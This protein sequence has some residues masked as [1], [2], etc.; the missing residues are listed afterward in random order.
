MEFINNSLDKN[1]NWFWGISGNYSISINFINKYANK[2][3]GCVYLSYN[4]NLSFDDIINNNN[5]NY[6][7]NLD[8]ISNNSMKFSKIRWINNYRLKII[9]ALQIQRHLRNCISNPLFKLSR[10]KIINMLKE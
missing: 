10:N 9:K 7:W 2:D 5:S 1:I 6:Y 8:N 3:W 4:P